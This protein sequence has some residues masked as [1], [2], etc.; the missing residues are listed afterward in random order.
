MQGKYTYS[1]ALPRGGALYVEFKNNKA[2]ADELMLAFRADDK[3]VQASQ[4]DSI[5]LAD[6]IYD[7]QG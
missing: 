3:E 5:E 7:L 4:L 2:A 1:R 6:A